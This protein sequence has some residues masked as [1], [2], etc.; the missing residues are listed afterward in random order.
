MGG[1]RKGVS[2]ITCCMNRNKNLKAS[3]STWL[4]VPDIS[5]IIIVDWSSK[6][7]VKNIL[8]ENTNGK[9][10][11]L[12]QVPN[13]DRWVLTWA[14]NLASTFVSFSEIA[15]IDADILLCKDFFESHRL[16]GSNFFHGSWRVARTDNELHL[17]GQAF[18]KTRDFIK[19]NG[20]H[21]GITS[22]GW[23]DDDLYFRLKKLGLKENFINSD[24]LYHIESKN[25]ER[26]ENQREFNAFSEKELGK[27]LFNETVKN[28][29]WAF[30]NPWRQYD[31]RNNWETSKV[32]SSVYIDIYT[33]K[34]RR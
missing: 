6:D 28:R 25:K 3:L 29:E 21:E 30:K 19:V 24:K 26:S 18:F 1:L 5:E 33:C 31:K 17:N 20:Y 2:L 4:S 11:K 13:Q 23:D 15:K 16:N 14:Y 27:I 34:R 10:I 12:I 8:P 7:S 32:S 22:Y 9:R